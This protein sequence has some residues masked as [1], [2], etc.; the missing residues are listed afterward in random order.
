MSFTVKG[1]Y[2]TCGLGLREKTINVVFKALNAN[3][4]DTPQTVV[5][6]CAPESL[7][8]LSLMLLQRREIVH[9]LKTISDSTDLYEKVEDVFMYK[10]KGYLDWVE[11]GEMEE[12]LFDVG[13]EDLPSDADESDLSSSEE[14]DELE[15]RDLHDMLNDK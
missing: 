14:D 13:N 4:T 10:D 1:W 7:L 9:F 6:L 12:L 2:S 11:E 8:S 3:F 15:D 5:Q